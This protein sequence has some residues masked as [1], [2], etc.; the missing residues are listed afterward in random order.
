MVEGLRST[1]PARRLRPATAEELA[2]MLHQAQQVG[3]KVLP[4]GGGRLLGMGQV[5]ERIDLALE[6]RGLDRVVAVTPADL[7]L[8][9]EAG[10]TLEEIDAALA[11]VGQQLPIDP[12]GGPGHTIG[13]VLASGVTGPLR[14]RFGAPR[15]FVIGMRVAL[16]DGRLCASGGRVVKNVS[17]YDMAKLHLGAL[18]CLGIVVAASF[19]VFPRPAE[20][21]TVKVSGSDAWAEASRALALPA[22]PVALEVNRDGTVRARFWGQ[23]RGLARMVEELGWD[24]APGEEWA[25]PAADGGETWARVSVPP[26]HLRAIL[27]RAPA[28]GDWW[29][30]P[31]IGIAH[32]RGRP[33][34]ADLG[35]LRSA[36]EAAGGGLVLLGAPEPLRV[37][38]GAWGTPPAT[39]AWMERLRASF[40][41]DRTIAPGRYLVR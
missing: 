15:E 5:P 29:A 31:G 7:T 26:R 30:W 22:P 3:E 8:T 40:D 10:V 32:L 11:P 2:E 21:I 1:A 16:P 13:G 38:V 39:T 6:T 18:G 25:R 9:V 19:K 23:G 24:R 17:G 41:P 35:R 20:D 27:E 34:A 14:Q 37:E 33:S 28:D 36:A 4:V 12:P